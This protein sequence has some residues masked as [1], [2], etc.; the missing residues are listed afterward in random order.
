MHRSTILSVLTLAAVAS[1][2]STPTKSGLEAREKAR[3]QLNSFTASFTYDQA[4]QDFEV[5]QFDRALRSIDDAIAQAP[6]VPAFHVLKGRVYF[7]TDRLERAMES[8][9]AAIELD[10]QLAE[11]HYFCGIVHQRWSDDQSAYEQYRMAYEI[12]P[13]RPEYLLAAAEGLVELGSY[14]EA[15]ALVESKLSYFEHNPA[16]RHLLGQIAL[17]EGNPVLAAELYTESVMLDPDNVRMLEELTWVQYEAGLYEECID[18]IDLIDSKTQEERID[19][20]HL[21]ARCQ[22][23][24]GNTA[25]AQRSYSDLTRRDASN[26]AVWIEFGTLSWKMGDYRRVAECSVRAISLAPGRY[27]GYLLKGQYE[28][29][30]GRTDEAIKLFRQATGLADGSAL[31]HLM[32]GRTLEEAGKDR[33]ALNAYGDALEIDPGNGEAQSLFTRLERKLK[34][35][36]A[37]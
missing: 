5:G 6:D 9:N 10:P 17:L 33:E 12:E 36:S 37:E 14:D 11:A 15:R 29:H 24:L 3:E 34:V 1:G 7:E 4:K 23:L 31:P 27:E 30:N 8:F 35:A 28:R 26:P 20:Q 21:Q 16:M 22:T 19:L 13:D 25:E 32:L 18:T 2:C